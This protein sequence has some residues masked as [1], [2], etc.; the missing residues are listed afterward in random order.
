MP[1]LLS[2]KYPTCEAIRS[3]N[4]IA[5]YLQQYCPHLGIGNPHDTTRFKLLTSTTASQFDLIV[6]LVAHNDG[7]LYCPLWKNI[8]NSLK[9][10]LEQAVIAVFDEVKQFPNYWIVEYCARKHLSVK[11]ENGRHRGTLKD[12]SPQQMAALEPASVVE[13]SGM[14]H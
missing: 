6:P 11:N 3:Y 8:P 13:E 2:A 5:K 10:K 14:F 4:K 1:K 7:K 9:H 12:A